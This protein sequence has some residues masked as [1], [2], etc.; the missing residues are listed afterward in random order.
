MTEDASLNAQ[1]ATDRGALARAFACAFLFFLVIG[2]YYVAK[3]VRDSVL[4]HDFEPG[5]YPKFY[6]AV[7]ILTLPIGIAI[8]ALARKW[9]RQILLPAVYVACAA[10]FLAFWWAYRTYG[11]PAILCGAF[12][13]WA[14]IYNVLTIC[15]FW[16]FT[17]DLFTKEQGKRLYGIVG[18][19]GI[20]GGWAGGTIASRLAERV[21]SAG[22]L[23]MVAGGL[24]LC[25]L[26]V[27]FL[28]MSHPQGGSRGQEARVAMRLDEVARI[29]AS[30]YVAAIA[31][32]VVLHT[33]SE[34]TVDLQSKSIMK[35]EHLSRDAATHFYGSFYAVMNG[36][37]FFSQLVGTTAFNRL[38][39]PRAGLLVLPIATLLFAPLLLWS[40]PAQAVTLPLF[41]TISFQAAVVAGV[42]VPLMA[43]A[44]SIQ[45]S[46]K[47]LLYVP[48]DASVK[49]QAKPF[50]DMFGFR[51]GDTLT[52]LLAL[53]AGSAGV[54]RVGWFAGMGL[55]GCCVWLVFAW[56]AGTRFNE[57]RSATAAPAAGTP[58]GP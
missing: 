12:F 22:L 20:V 4:V 8:A 41:G 39:G 42:G 31:A 7:C 43:F 23:P 34:T 28:H 44:Y 27:V 10:V 40:P 15:L 38:W 30:P 37:A 56:R 35:S 54:A 2:S 1:D 26:G 18:A 19:G 36:F 5:A 48:T 45:Q 16:A 6:I 9:P 33:F 57:L 51:F 11:S 29:L 14:S 55:A 50:I 58:G 13:I 47:E 53:L 32:V 3:S 46:S 52:S 17:N 25:A 21:G 49:Y 24:V